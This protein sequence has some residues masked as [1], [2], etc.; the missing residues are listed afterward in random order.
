LRKPKGKVQLSRLEE[1]SPFN[2]D[3]NKPI[4]TTEKGYNEGKAK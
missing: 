4:S 1:M 3:L 2:P